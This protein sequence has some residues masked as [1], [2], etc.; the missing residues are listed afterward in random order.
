MRFQHRA[1]SVLRR[2]A[3]GWSGN[4][5]GDRRADAASR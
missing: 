1:E 3:W 2:T 4:A 5:R